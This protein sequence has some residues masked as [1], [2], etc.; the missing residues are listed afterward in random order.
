M[1]Q[2]VSF[3]LCHQLTAD[4]SRGRPLSILK[5]HRGRRQMID[6]LTPATDGSSWLAVLNAP[7]DLYIAFA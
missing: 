7:E 6:W 2:S 5:V 4:E 1:T 3:L